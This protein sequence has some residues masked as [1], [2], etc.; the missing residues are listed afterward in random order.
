[1]VSVDDLLVL[2]NGTTVDFIFEEIQE[3]VLLKRIGHLKP[4]KP[5]RFLGRNIER[6]GNYC[7]LGLQDSY[8]NNMIERLD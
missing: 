5:Q 8:I 6:C 7:T 2:G 3:Q 1:M 4:G